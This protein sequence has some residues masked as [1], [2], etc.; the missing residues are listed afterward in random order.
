MTLAS[1]LTRPHVLGIAWPI[2]LSNIATPLLGLVDTAVIGNLGNASLLGG[3]A[4][5]S[6]IFSFL[7]WGFGFLR[8]GTTALTAQSVGS[9]QFEDAAAVFY[10]AALLGFILG[11][12]LLLCRNPIGTI[13]FQLIGGTSEV[14]SAA[15]DYFAIRILGAPFNLMLLAIFGYFL[16]CQQ[17]RLV[18]YLNVLLN[19]LNIILDLVFV[20]GFDWDVKGVALA[21]VVSEV[22]VFTI[23]FT[24][25]ITRHY[26]T[27]GSVKIPMSV[28]INV[29]QVRRMFVVNRDIMIRT[30]CLIFAFAW[31]TN[32]GAHQG[33]TIL[34][35]NAILMQFVTFAAFFLDGFALAAESLVGSATGAN[36][37]HQVNLVIRYVFELGGITALLTTL[38]FWLAGDTIIDLLTTAESVRIA[39]RE[40]LWWAICA[41][42]VSVACYLLDG[43]FI[44]ATKTVEMRNAMIASLLIFLGCYYIAV[45]LFD[46]HGLWLALHGYF[47]ARALTLYYYL[48]RIQPEPF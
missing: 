22:V 15:A 19:G 40:Y 31:F 45:P 26:K 17:T 4:I 35:A 16:G 9:K 7:F 36:D 14:E 21:T 10:R 6:M 30:L 2:I 43:I 8:M 23:G 32:Q 5:G 39:A 33:D 29:E 28:I 41:P 48:P 46:N 34:A 42:V 24:V 27:A 1:S 37:Q 38:G 44:G 47:A 18:L 12:T 3:I 13:A 25:L 20:M 11:I